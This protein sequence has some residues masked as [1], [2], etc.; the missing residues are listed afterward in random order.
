MYKISYTKT[1]A[2]DLLKLDRIVA[3]RIA[4]K[5]DFFALQKDIKPFCKSLT[6]LGSKFRFR[7]GDYRAI[8]QIDNSGN[9]Q[10][11]MILRIKHRKDIY[12]L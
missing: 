1:A 3:Q 4:K 9:I 6:G 7:I 8:F 12:D 11:L 2:E 5:I 10:I